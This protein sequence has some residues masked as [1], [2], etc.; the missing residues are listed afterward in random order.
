M[1][2]GEIWWA[3]LEAPFGSGPGD[4]RP[5]VIVS[6]DRFNRG[7]IGTVIIAIVT[8]NLR[9]ANHPGNFAVSHRTSG[10]PRTSVV[11]VSQVMTVDRTTLSDLIGHLTASELRKLDDG[12]RLVLAL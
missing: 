3:D 8:S 5:A 7:A 12:L 4:R 2:R 1:L 10:L 6:S 9:I 11:N